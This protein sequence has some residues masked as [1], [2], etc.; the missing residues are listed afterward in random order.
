MFI[1]SGLAQF[2]SLHYVLWLNLQN[3]IDG[4][5]FKIIH[6]MYQSIKSC[7]PLNGQTTNFFLCNIGLQQG[8]NLSPALFSLFL[9]DLEQFL[10]V[11]NC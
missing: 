2:A 8:E 5:F 1:K 3:N 4:K 6:N 7:M 9:N 11:S 10:T